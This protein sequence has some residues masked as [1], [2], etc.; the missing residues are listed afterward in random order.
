MQTATNKQNTD[1]YLPKSNNTYSTLEPAMIQDKPKNH[2][3]S[4]Q[5]LEN[6]E[7]LFLFNPR[8]CVPPKA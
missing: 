5:I 6:H 4:F 7:V 8:F 2:K 1:L 3:S